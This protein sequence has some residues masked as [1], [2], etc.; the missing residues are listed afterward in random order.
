MM[1]HTAGHVFG[2][3]SAAQLGLLT[4]LLGVCA[5]NQEMDIQST[6]SIGLQP[7]PK[8]LGRLDNRAGYETCSTIEIM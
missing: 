7:F 8:K 1:D 4:R 5:L 6:C 3:C 2:L